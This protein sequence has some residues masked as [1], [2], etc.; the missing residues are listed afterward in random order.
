MSVGAEPRW[1]ERAARR[2]ARGEVAA[3][4]P[5]GAQEGGRLS[6]RTLLRLAGA[7]ALFGGGPLRLLV[8]AS[9]RADALSEC[10][11]IAARQSVVFFEACVKQPLEAYE[12]YKKAIETATE[13]LR[14]TKDPAK[15]RR[16]LQIIDKSTA[17]EDR[18]IRKVESC[19]FQFAS[20]LS[21]SEQNCHAQYPPGS[22]GGGNGLESG[23]SSC[24]P[25]TAACAESSVCCF[26]N[27]FCCGCPGGTTCCI[28]AD[29]RCCP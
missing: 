10:T 2:A 29:C 7:A 6:R 24:P 1:L 8:P 27:D 5:S 20:D 11:R 19:N 21:G 16:L 17:G 18:A 26:G 9:A 3:E 23:P 4:T 12:T 13:A 15:R 28:Y 25:G 14:R 22:G